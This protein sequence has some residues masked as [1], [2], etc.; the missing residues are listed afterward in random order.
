MLTFDPRFCERD[1]RPEMA[2]LRGQRWPHPAQKSRAV[3]PRF[4]PPF[5]RSLDV[6]RRPDWLAV[7]PVFYELVSA[8]KFPITGKIQGISPKRPPGGSS[9]RLTAD[10]FDGFGTIPCNRI[11]EFYAPDQRILGPQLGIIQRSRPEGLR[12]CRGRRRTRISAVCSPSSP[13]E[14][15]TRPTVSESSERS[16]LNQIVGI[17]R[18]IQLSRRVSG[19]HRLAAA[20]ALESWQ[21][22]GDLR[23][24]LQRP[25]CL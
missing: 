14:T 12:S 23:N 16:S 13:A 3:W 4:C 17:M 9:T 11:S 18:N 20:M 24:L 15:S 1:D 10:P 7:Q 8:A 6:V 19:C 21:H 25:P 22:Y 5:R 2:S